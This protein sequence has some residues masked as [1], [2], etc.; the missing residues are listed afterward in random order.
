MEISIIDA[1]VIQ[2]QQHRPGKAKDG[3]NKQ[4]WEAA[5]NVKTAS[6]GKLKTTYGYK[7]HCNVDEEGL[8]KA[9]T[10]TPGNVHDSQ[11]FM[12]L[13]SGTEKEVC[14]DSAYASEKTNSYL[15]EKRIGNGVLERAYCNKPLT[16][17]QKARN[18]IKSRIR[19]TVE[20][21]FGILKQHYGMGQARYLDLVRNQVRFSLMCV[22]YNIKRS[23]SLRRE[24]QSRQEKCV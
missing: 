19:S 16:A 3:Q 2:A 20:R 6:D 8:I 7:A 15:K 13:I 14:A 18:E 24:C 10:F 21:T 11:C 17:A 12:Q 1:S 22:A 4:D 5:Y 23:L 9:H